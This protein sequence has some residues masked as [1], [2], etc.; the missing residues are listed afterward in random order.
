MKTTGLFAP[1][2]ALAVITAITCS[3]PNRFAGGSGHEWEAKAMVRGAVIDTS[4][5]GPYVALVKLLPAG[6][7]PLSGNG[8]PTDTTD[9]RGGF[10]FSGVEIGDYAVEARRIGSG[11]RCRT[12]T[13]IDTP[14]VD[15]PPETL[16]T[17]G[18]IVLSLP[19]NSTGGAVYIPGTTV[20]VLVSALQHTI[21]IDSL[22]PGLVQ[23]V[24][25]MATGDTAARASLAE[26]LAV[27]P[28][29]RDSIADL[30]IYNDDTTLVTGSYPNPDT[31]VRDATG[32]GPGKR[33]YTFT[34]TIRDW[35]ATCG[36]NLDNWTM[37]HSYDVSRYSVIRFT[38]KGTNP[39]HGLYLYLIDA[40]SRDQHVRAGAI[41]KTPGTAEVPLSSYTGLNLTKLREIMFLV[42]DADTGSGVLYFNNVRFSSI[43]TLK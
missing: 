17:P 15:I 16:K 26:S 18:A 9:G 27:L 5:T 30:V 19:D 41:A 43:K 13:R 31:L 1:Y 12:M 21:S 29:K 36:L 39:E 25:F 33:P 34:Y 35:S 20:R 2:F 24:L 22:A 8:V 11:L 14:L 4:C 40:T 32:V 28:G 6:Y 23:S 42:S 3:S 7:S 10:A 37:G 38:Y